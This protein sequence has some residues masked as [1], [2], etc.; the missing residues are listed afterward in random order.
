MQKQEIVDEVNSYQDTIYAIVGFMNLFRF[1]DE[2]GTMRDNVLLFQGCKLYPIDLTRKE[3]VEKTQR[4]DYVTPDIG[5]V[6]SN[7]EGIIGEVKASFPKDTSLWMDDFKQLM[8]YDQT[9]EG[10][11]TTS[12]TIKSHDIVLLLHYSRAV[13]VRKFYEERKG[14][15]IIFN[16]S[17]CIIEFQRTSQSKEYFSLRIQYG[18]LSESTVGR[19]LEEGI[20]IPMKIF[21]QTYS[22]YKIYDAKPP[23]PYLLDIIWTHIITLK[24]SDNP[25]FRHLRK[26]QKIE[27]ELEVSEITELLYKQFS[28]VQFPTDENTLAGYFEKQPKYPKQSWVHKACERL[29]KSGDATWVD[30]KK[31]QIRFKFKRRDNVFNYFVE[32]CLSDDKDQLILFPEISPN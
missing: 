18:S 25:K 27:I 22:T 14:K 29:V 30:E 10:W 9:L 5:I 3:E 2:R 13:A 6:S 20:Q 8:K 4:S 21:V 7:N 11:P 32:I 15:E 23:L 24:A 16:R 19:R 31:E 17:F 28:F 26:N 12:G 1:D